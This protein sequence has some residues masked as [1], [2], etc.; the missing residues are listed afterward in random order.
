[1]ELKK[2]SS[3][4]IFDNS[5]KDI[6]DLKRL[7]LHIREFSKKLEKDI[8][9][10]N[11]NTFDHAKI[12]EREIKK[13]IDKL[14]DLTNQDFTL[15]YHILRNLNDYKIIM[16]KQE[17]KVEFGLTKIEMRYAQN[18]IDQIKE[19]LNGLQKIFKKLK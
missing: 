17:K 14:F 9:E 2:K 11:I 10:N 13:E 19:K 5:Y 8:K 12:F 16:G 3:K 6:Q 18:L 1:M 7:D 4:A 15:Y